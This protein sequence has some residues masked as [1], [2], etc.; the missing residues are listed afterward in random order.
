MAKKSL[1][2]TALTDEIRRAVLR[3]ALDRYHNELLADEERMLLLDRGSG[4]Y[5]ASSG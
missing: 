2:E 4:G 5:V 1:L 3:E